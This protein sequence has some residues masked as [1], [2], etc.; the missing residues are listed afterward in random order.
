MAWKCT[1]PRVWYSATLATDTR[2][3]VPPGPLRDAEEPG[4]GPV[5][6][7]DGAVPQG[8]GHG[9]EDDGGGVV[10][11]V[12]V[13]GLADAGVVGLV[14]AIAAGFAVGVAALRA[15]VVAEQVAVDGAE[16]RGGEG[17]EDLGVGGDGV[18]D[19][20]AAD[21][22]G[23]DELVGVGSVGLGAGWA[24]GAAP[25]PAGD[26]ELSARFGFA[27]VGGE[28]LSGGGVDH[29]GLADQVDGLGA[30]AGGGDHGPPATETGIG[31]GFDQGGEGPG[32]GQVRPGAHRNPPKPVSTLVPCRSAAGNGR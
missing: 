20:F 7:G 3:D 13:E 25:V 27:V 10:V 6:Q 5:D 14:A 23:A 18:G 15:A 1:A 21:E 24:A 9:V 30:A 12:G 11:A 32:I 19:G 8:G 17:G 4:R 28:D 16:G 22:T 2:P 26:Q 31:G 29:L